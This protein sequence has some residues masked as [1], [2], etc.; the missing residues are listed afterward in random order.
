MSVMEEL[1]RQQ[2]SSA[3]EGFAPLDDESNSKAQ[4]VHTLRWNEL[5]SEVRLGGSWL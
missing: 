5:F 2:R 1:E 4:L 3:F